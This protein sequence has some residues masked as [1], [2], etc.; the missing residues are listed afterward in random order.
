MAMITS[1][2]GLYK[3]FIKTSRRMEKYI[4]LSK[5]NNNHTVLKELIFIF[6]LLLPHKIINM[7]NI[8]RTKV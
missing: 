4:F 2:V 7:Y 3:V 6:D 5:L 1:I 8:Q